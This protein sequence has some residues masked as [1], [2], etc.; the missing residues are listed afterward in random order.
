MDIDSCL[1]AFDLPEQWS[2]RGY[3]SAQLIKQ[4]MTSVW[5][6]A[7]KFEHTEVTRQ[8]EVIHQFWGFEKMTGHKSFQRFFNKFDLA[9]N[10]KV[11]TGLYQWFFK[12]L[13]FNNLTLDVDSTIHTRYGTQQ[14]AKKGYNTT[15]RSRDDCLITP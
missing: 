5:C 9:T 6:G 15:Q 8:D 4:F 7:N 1:E 13:Q 2:N 3:S 10:Q 14:G 11:F 12:N